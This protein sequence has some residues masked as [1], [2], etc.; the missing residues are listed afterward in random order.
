MAR[1][2][3]RTLRTRSPAYQ[4]YGCV[5]DNKAV[6][7]DIE[8]AEPLD[9]RLA[10]QHG[11]TFRHVRATDSPSPAAAIYAARA[12]NGAGIADC[13]NGVRMLSPKVL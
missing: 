4:P 5:A 12:A 13:I 2:V 10:R 9:E 7:V 1:E 3:P 11:P 6:A 8:S